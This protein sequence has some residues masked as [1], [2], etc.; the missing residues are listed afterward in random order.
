MEKIKT[1]T[2]YCSPLPQHFR[3]RLVTNTGK[4]NTPS[5]N[6]FKTI[7]S[8][9]KNQKIKNFYKCI[10]ITIYVVLNEFVTENS[11]VYSIFCCF[12]FLAFPLAAAPLNWHQVLIT[13]VSATYKENTNFKEPP[14]K[15]QNKKH[16]F[17]LICLVGN[18]AI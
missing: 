5:Q 10:F 7:I 14:E 13:F 2:P 12:S 18:N 4:G 6:K 15:N 9:E 16:T 11:T 1:N 17:D 8:P 3:S